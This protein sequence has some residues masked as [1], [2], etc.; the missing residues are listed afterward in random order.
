MD[1]ATAVV[2]VHG[3]GAGPASLAPL[4]DRLV[5]AGMRPVVVH[6]AGYGRAAD[7]PPAPIG[8]QVDGLAGLC[9]GVRPAAVVGVSGGATLALLLAVRLAGAVPVVAHEPLV[10]PLA[11]ALHERVARAV[12]G[13][14][15]PPTPCEAVRFVRRLVGAATWDALPA[16]ERRFVADH[17]SLIATEARRF[18]DVAPAAADLAAV[19]PFVTTVGAASGP[20]RRAA[21]GVLARLS[22]ARVETVPGAAHLAHVDAPDAFA[23]TVLAA[24]SGGTP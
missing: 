18:A 13:F 16:A 2:L 10:G 24:S 4:A 21:A 9:T 15:D 11:P 5:A 23:A 14:G 3:V 20:E 1:A 22:G 7:R 12:A 19:A 17:P 6:R 8:V